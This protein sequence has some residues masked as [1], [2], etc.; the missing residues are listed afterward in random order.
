MTKIEIILL[1][2][3]IAN[4]FWIIYTNIK[5]DYFEKH[6]TDNFRSFLKMH[7][8]IQKI[9]ENQ[10][11][12]N[13]CFASELDKINNILKDEEVKVENDYDL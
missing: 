11:A 9:E 8:S 3:N 6:V 10:S 1:L 2:L 4:I 12:L 13:K 7:E 5:F